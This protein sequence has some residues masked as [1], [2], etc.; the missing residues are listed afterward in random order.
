MKT[1]QHT[2]SGRLIVIWTLLMTVLMAA[3][4]FWLARRCFIPVPF[5]LLSGWLFHSLTIEITGDELCWRFGPGIVAKRVRLAEIASVRVVR[6]NFWEGW[7]IHRSRFGWLYNVAGRGAVALVLQNGKKFALGT[8][9]PD[10]LV[11]ALKNSGAIIKPFKA[12]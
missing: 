10:A 3:A 5:L 12:V 7:G 4:G 6:T 2:Q 1:Y 8:D 11:A 9:E